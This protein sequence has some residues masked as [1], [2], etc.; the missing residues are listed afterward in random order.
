MQRR[1]R[2]LLPN[3]AEWSPRVTL[4]HT[5]NRL[6]KGGLDDVRA[7]AKSVQLPKLVVIDTF[8]RVRP[9]KDKNETPYDADYRA[10]SLLQELATELGVAIVVIHHQVAGRGSQG[11]TNDTNQK[12]TP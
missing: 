1:I 12:T 8:T 3:T 9:A 6:D 7:W 5:M 4:C 10:M 2:Q 11:L